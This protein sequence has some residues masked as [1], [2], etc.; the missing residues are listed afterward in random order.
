MKTK[1]LLTI[2]VVV[3][4]A[5]ILYFVF[6]QKKPS[7]EAVIAK[8]TTGDKA[9]N[10]LESKLNEEQLAKFRSWVVEFEKEQATESKRALGW[11]KQ[12]ETDAETL[13]IPQETAMYRAILYIM[14]NDQKLLTK[15]ELT[16]INTD[17]VWLYR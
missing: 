1:T 16:Q 8:E 5:V 4:A 14:Q 15:D 12:F 13:G 7:T 10:Y 2:I 3:L 6:K 9:I 17:L 11:R